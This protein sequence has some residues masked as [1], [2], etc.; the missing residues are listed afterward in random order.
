MTQPKMVPMPLADLLHNIHGS[1]I[2]EQWLPVV[3]LLHEALAQERADHKAT[4]QVM[5]KLVSGGLD[6]N[7]ITVTDEAWQLK[8]ERP[9]TQIV[10]GWPEPKAPSP[11]KGSVGGGGQYPENGRDTDGVANAAE[12]VASTTG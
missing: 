12:I 5:Q 9:T 7:G 11:F 10:D 4:L 3:K 6:G 2:Q 8:P 1:T